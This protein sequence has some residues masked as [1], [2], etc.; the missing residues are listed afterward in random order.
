MKQRSWWSVPVLLTLGGASAVAQ[1][2]AQPAPPAGGWVGPVSPAA[3][4]PPPLL[5][6]SEAGVLEDANAGRTFLAP[7][8]LMSPKGSWTFSD[9]ELFL[10]GGSYAFSDD[11][12]ASAVTMLPLFDGQPFI[13]LFTGKVRLVRQER[14]HVAA[15]HAVRGRRQRR[16]RERRLDRRRHLRLSPGAP[17]ASAASSAPASPTR[18]S[19]A[20]R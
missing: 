1:P 14:L 2:S 10:V 5:P 12:A 7:T 17:P 15:G 19:R 9:W 4:E 20:C 13:G 11:V 18:I 3:E 6:A 8:A 16:R